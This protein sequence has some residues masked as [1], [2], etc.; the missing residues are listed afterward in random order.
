MTKV[1]AAIVADHLSYLTEKHQLLPA[2]HFGGR[3][4]RTTTD[5]IHLLT[6]KI[7]DAWRAGK[8]AAILF[9]DIEG[10]FPNAVPEHLAQNLR[11]RGVPAKYVKFV[12]NMLKNRVTKLKFDGYESK[13]YSINNGIGQGDP[14]SMILYQFYN[15]DLLDIPVNKSESA[16]AYVDDALMVVI[17]DTFEEAHRTLADMMT[18]EGGVMD[19]SK[20]HNS[21][22]EYSKLALIDFAHPAS[23]KERTS[24]LLPSREV[25]PA[26]STKY[27]GVILD[28]HLNWKA[29]HA[30]AIKKGAI[31]AAQI[32]RVA[33]PSWGITPNYARR[34]YISVALPRVL[35]GMDLWCHPQQGERNDKA[36]R[37]SA[38][39]LKQLASVQRA[40]TI[41]ITGALR[42]S[43]TDTLN[44]LAFL[45]PIAMTVDKICHRALT[46]LSMLPKD[47]PLHP[48]I[49]RNANRRVKRHR[50][51]IHV[52]LSLY[53]L[54]PNKIEKIPSFARNPQQTGKLPFAISIAEDRQSS[55]A[56]VTNAAEEIQVFADGSAIDGKVGAAAVLFKQGG[57][58]ETLHFHLGP[59]SEHTVHEAELVG[60]VL[61][62]HLINGQRKGH[63]AMAIGIDN[64][65]MLKAFHS[66]LRRPGHHLAREA[67]R[68]ANK[69]KKL[70][71]NTSYKLTVCW[72][73]GHEGIMGNE[74]ADAEAK[75]AAAG[76]SSLKSSLPPYLRKPIPQNPAALKRQHNDAL[77]Q[78][79]ITDWRGSTRGLKLK[80][81]VPDSPSPAYLKRISNHNLTRRTVSL[82]S[83]LITTHIPLNAYL[84]RFKI[85]EKD[86]CP[87]CGAPS[88]DVPHFL[89]QCPSYAHERWL[90]IHTAKKIRKPLSLATILSE[91]KML[92]SLAKY[93]ETTHRFDYNTQ[94]EYPAS[95]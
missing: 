72:A 60:L 90:M 80:E 12:E 93:L 62:L 76:L 5:A 57:D 95:P 56:E 20:T 7:K 70:R 28:Q 26:S 32:R 36:I 39:V 23:T 78:S 67:L 19:W 88:E 61:G 73:A 25:K 94:S 50:T 45:L 85:V 46:R 10:A 89:L 42:T 79:W 29:Q 33:K 37:G 75:K 11:K 91:P 64:Q 38:K 9:L 14:L 58:S 53:H 65:A 84:R 13:N 54:D 21:P 43:P 49:K 27:L 4:G 87:A 34:L 63:K 66:D 24:L 52:L 16:I 83:Q 92:T 41:A 18:R 17:A 82:I 31:W 35:Y 40:G 30:N 74:M 48:I 55:I 22:L 51:P 59:E 86:Q 3:P 69:A 6:C 68:M 15:A 8:V 44:V 77:K 81:I 2:H 47:H 1:I 71:G